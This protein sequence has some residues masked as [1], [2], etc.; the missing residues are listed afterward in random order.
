[1]TEKQYALVRLALEFLSLGMWD[2][3]SGE[4]CRQMG[5]DILVEIRDEL[6]QHLKQANQERS[7]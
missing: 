7:V 1:M 2:T 6:R 5:M 4:F 3:P